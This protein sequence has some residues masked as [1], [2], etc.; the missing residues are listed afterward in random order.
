M[1]GKDRHTGSK[2]GSNPTKVGQDD[3]DIGETTFLAG[4]DEVSGGL[5]R[6]IGHLEV[7]GV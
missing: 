7:G 6:L 3:L 2:K 5:E 1:P 4:H